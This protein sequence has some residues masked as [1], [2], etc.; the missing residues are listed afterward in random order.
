MSNLIIFIK[1]RRREIL[2]FFLLFLISS[3][4]FG[5]GYLMRGEINRTP[6]VIEKNSAN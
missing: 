6:I 2:L 1:S 3:I 5:L 4:S